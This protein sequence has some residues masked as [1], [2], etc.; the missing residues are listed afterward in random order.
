VLCAEGDTLAALTEATASPDPAPFA[1]AVAAGRLGVWL[2][3][4]AHLEQ[5][6]LQA[7]GAPVTLRKARPVLLPLPPDAPRDHVDAA[8]AAQIEALAP[9]MATPPPFAVPLTVLMGG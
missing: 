5:L 1:E 2:F 7:T 4:H 9:L 3:G 8:L 6:A